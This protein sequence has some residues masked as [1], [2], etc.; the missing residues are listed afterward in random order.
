MAQPEGPT[1]RICNCVLV[2]LGEKKEKKNWQHMLAQVPIF[3]NKQTD[4]QK[5]LLLVALGR[6]GIT[7]LA[8][9]S[10]CSALGNNIPTFF[11]HTQYQRL[12]CCV[13]GERAHF[14]SVTGAEHSCIWP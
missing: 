2:G 11:H 10:P 6:A 12:A 7:A 1:T 9:H 4:K 13:T 14:G 3:K 5:N 8:A